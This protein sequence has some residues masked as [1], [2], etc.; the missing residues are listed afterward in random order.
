MGF[1]LAASKMKTLTNWF[2]LLGW[3]SLS[4]PE[5]AKP[6]LNPPTHIS[7][8]TGEVFPEEVMRKVVSS[9]MGMATMFSFGGFLKTKGNYSK[10]TYSNLTR[11]S[12]GLKGGILGFD[13]KEANTSH[14]L[15]DLDA[16]KR[17]RKEIQKLKAVQAF[18]TDSNW[19]RME[20]TIPE[21]A[22][23]LQ[24][25]RRT[26]AIGATV[27]VAIDGEKFDANKDGDLAR[28]VELAETLG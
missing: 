8:Y 25:S 26:P 6:I 16:L 7:T 10:S 14:P 21:S 22:Y 27:T 19:E 24:C 28:L 18:G 23:A 9:L 12:Q 1:T 11:N 13:P 15:T 17:N 3:K 5:T 20:L 4:R 2:D